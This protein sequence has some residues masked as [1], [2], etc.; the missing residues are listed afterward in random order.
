[1]K[2]F[3]TEGKTLTHTVAADIES[4][5]GLLID[6]V[7]GVATKKLLNGET[8][9]FLIEGVVVLPK[10]STDTFNNG[11]KVFWDEGNKRLTETASTHQPVGFCFAAAGNGVTTVPLKL[12]P[13]TKDTDT[14][15][16]G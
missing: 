9:E 2:N 1:M 10:L 3:V 7:L 12:W 13:M 4:G 8:G 16:G 5:V 11:Q 15:G 6:G 14:I